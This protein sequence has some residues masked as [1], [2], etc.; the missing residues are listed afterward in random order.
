MDLD[1]LATYGRSPT[2]TAW[3]T[4]PVRRVL[5]WLVAPYFRGA[6]GEID[7]HV[8]H[9]TAEIDNRMRDF[10]ADIDEKQRAGLASLHE[11][12]R[13]AIASQL[14]GVRKDAMAVA[15]RLAGLEEEAATV[16]QARDA[17]VAE[18]YHRT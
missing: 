3:V 13:A 16:A 8:G 6:G 7:R 9:V 2:S 17:V 4:N 12:V 10:V 18:H 5:W 1:H 15:H 14:G 11:T